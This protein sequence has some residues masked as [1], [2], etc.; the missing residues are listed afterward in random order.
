[1]AFTGLFSLTLITI[2]AAM[3]RAIETETTKKENG[4]HDTSYVWM[5]GTIQA[6]LGRSRLTNRRFHSLTLQNSR[7]RVVSV[8][9]PSTLRSIHSQGQA[10]VDTDGDVL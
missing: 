7:Y 6:S 5:W 2:A 10:Q 9:I 8:S 1:M 4:V 3:A